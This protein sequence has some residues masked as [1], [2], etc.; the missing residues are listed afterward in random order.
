MR[1]TAQ[2]TSSEKKVIVSS[3][4]TQNYYTL[5]VKDYD[6]LLTENVTSEYTKAT[7]HMVHDANCKAKKWVTEIGSRGKEL[8]RRVQVH[9]EEQ[10]FITLKDHKDD[11]RKSKSLPCR[12]IKPSKADLGKISK[13]RL[14]A[15]TKI[16]RAKTMHNQWISTADVIDWFRGIK[17][18]RRM[19]FISH[20]R[21]S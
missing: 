5:S 11:F 17:N 4:K 8:A 15:I 14:E 13:K 21:K 20:D 6:K 18:K 9:S 12:L 2:S 7:N 3:D 1:E 16:I 19:S 10:A